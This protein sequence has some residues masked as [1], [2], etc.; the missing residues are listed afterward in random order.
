MRYVKY[1]YIDKQSKKLLSEVKGKRTPSTPNNTDFSFRNESRFDIIGMNDV[2]FFGT[3]DDFFDIES[4]VGIEEISEQEFLNARQTEYKNRILKNLEKNGKFVDYPSDIDINENNC[5]KSL[6]RYIDRKRDEQIYTNVEY[7]FPGEA[8]PD[9]IQLRDEKDRQNLQDNIIE[10]QF[11]K[12]N[13]DTTSTI[14][15]MPLSQN[16]KTLTPTEMLEMGMFMKERGQSIYE[17]SWLKKMEI[18]NCSTI[19]E[20]K[21]L[22]E[23]WSV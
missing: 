20:L 23:N 1:Y 2:V 3:V 19:S 18:E 4:T 16:K 21:D 6:R 10:A 14:D 9:Y 12:S 22:T 13:G 8:E 5:K 7:T 17:E 11:L 15:F